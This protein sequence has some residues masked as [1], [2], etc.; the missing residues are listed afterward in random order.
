MRG[1]AG[2][3][4]ISDTYVARWTSFRLPRGDAHAASP[5]FCGRPKTRWG[6]GSGLSTRRPPSF[7]ESPSKSFLPV[8]WSPSPG[9]LLRGPTPSPV[10]DPG[11]GPL[12]FLGPE[13]RGSGGDLH[14]FL[15]LSCAQK[16]STDPGYA[17]VFC[18][19]HALEV[20]AH[21]IRPIRSSEV[22]GGLDLIHP[23]ARSQILGAS[24]AWGSLSLESEEILST[25][26]GCL[27]SAGRAS[28][29][30]RSNVFQRCLAPSR[31]DRRTR[32]KNPIGGSVTTERMCRCCGGRMRAVTVARG[33]HRFSL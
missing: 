23:L 10:H 21:L 4:P 28:A 6:K 2:C 26:T 20:G 22:S 27:A 17:C 14:Q 32:T 15:A 16:A 5:M 9:F 11:V 24:T 30:R 33:A 1:I 29:G 8:P 3:P 13:I 7:L 25:E 18:T 12:L 19:Q 31:E